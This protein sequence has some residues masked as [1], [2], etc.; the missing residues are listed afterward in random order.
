MI[1]WFRNLKVAQKLALISIFFVMPDSVMLYLFITGINA[2]IEFARQE[3]KGNEYQRPLEDLLEF[4]PQHRQLVTQSIRGESV[5]AELTQKEAEIESA[6]D[7]LQE[8]DSRI[9][10]DLQFTPEGLAKRK[11]EHYKAAIVRAE[12]TKLR[13][14]LKDLDPAASAAQHLHLIADIRV[15][16]TH[17]GDLSNLI[18]DPDLDSYYLMDATLLALP[19]TQDRL[20]AVVAHG[21]AVLRQ[22]S[23]SN[24]EQQQL[25]IYATML[26]EAD[27]ERIQGSVQTG[28][29][30]DANF[31]G[32]SPTLQS[33]VP[34]AL[35][36]YV[37]CNE[38]FIKMIE[39]LVSSGKKQVSTTSYLAAGTLA[40][41]A[42]FN[43]W[44]ITDNELD[45]LL[46]IRIHA[47]QH[48][49][50]RSLF[51]AAAA[52]VAALC[53]VTFITRSISGPLR[54]QANDLTA[55]N[56]SLQAEI[57]DRKRAEAELRH[58]ENQLAIAQKI[59]RVGS[60]DWDIHSNIMHWSE[61]NYR[62]HGYATSGEKV[63]YDTA[64]QLIHPDDREFSD[65]TFK[66]ALKEKKPFSFEQRI[67][68]QDGTVRILQQNGEVLLHADGKVAEVFGTAQDVTERKLSEQELERVNKELI[69]VSREAGMAEVATGVLHNV[70][71][72]LNSVNVSAMLI[73]ER[74][75]KSRIAH[76]TNVAQLLEQ[77]S[78][79]LGKFLTTDPRGKMLPK[80]INTL[81]ERLTVEQAETLA[82]AER[83][84]KNITHIKDIVAVQQN[85][86]KV[87]GL[88]ESMPAS[89]LVEDALGMNGAAFDR[90]H[91]EVVRDFADV[92][93]VRVDKHKV[94][95]VLVNLIRNA[96]YAVSE[97]LRP[98]K[99][100][101]VR[102]VAS[103]K[104]R[105]KIIVADNGI[106]IA[107]E[108]LQRIFEHG[109]TTKE[110]GHGF[111]LHSA[112]LAASEMGGSLSVHSAGVGKGAT[113]T[114]EVPV[115]EETIGLPS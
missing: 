78:K 91:I 96:K 20:A 17:A 57:L 49:R 68:R 86:A 42:S 1:N 53:F 32:I 48:R 44:R 64:L 30:E 34:A 107:P 98:E 71:N 82:E 47:Y 88:L 19:E 9:G 29:N 56:D 83:L 63:S 55:A 85:Y 97:A 61:E 67:I 106:G 21:E 41:D 33:R 35:K 54:K 26:K 105:V 75:G 76:L 102:I 15:M 25:A 69:T 115:D 77:N 66:R 112:A 3:E 87:S 13:Q 38:N 90:H 62:I 79:N 114:L 39:L 46:E 95:Q 7:R 6:F 73:S 4:I 28:L 5:A 23:I 70:G 22:P 60:W 52:L 80:F 24:A 51:V 50:A 58:S 101:K 40:R 74:L 111:G 94:L 93:L 109:F 108:N 113:F 110:D 16:I 100:I 11:R 72:V 12:W 99:T 2:N 31:Y 103:G 14:S 10:T 89:E 18:L 59:A 8:I 36:Q 37:A 65:K 45:K 104:S 27:L 43:L 81:S 92:P 84:A